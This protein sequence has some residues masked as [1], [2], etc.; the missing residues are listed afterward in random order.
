MPAKKVQ[1]RKASPKKSQQ[2]R[3]YARLFDIEVKPGKAKVAMSSL[4]DS[5]IAALRAHEGYRGF[6]LFV[7]QGSPSAKAVAW[8]EYCG[9]P[10]D[11]F[12]RAVRSVR[13][14]VEGLRGSAIDESLYEVGFEDP[15][16]IITGG[17]FIPARGSRL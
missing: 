4:Q 6:Q 17:A 9:N 8:F 3:L 11:F 16:G 2:G 14:D 5:V 7:R 12:S 15:L 13:P 10:K 1:Q